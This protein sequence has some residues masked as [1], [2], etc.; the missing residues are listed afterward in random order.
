VISEI[1]V[2]WQT[3]LS[4]S[5]DWDYVLLIGQTKQSPFYLIMETISVSEAVCLIKYETM[6]AMSKKNNNGIV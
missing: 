2:L 1:S 5:S 4:V 3:L 6:A